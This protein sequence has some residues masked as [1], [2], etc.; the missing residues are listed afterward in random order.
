[1][2]HCPSSPRALQPPCLPSKSRDQR[3]GRKHIFSL[4]SAQP[5]QCRHHRSHLQLESTQ[6]TRP[7]AIVARSGSP[8]SSHRLSTIIPLLNAT[9]P[10]VSATGTY[11]CTQSRRTSSLGKVQERLW[12]R[13][14]SETTMSSTT[15]ANNAAAVFSLKS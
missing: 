5:R 8:S 2:F 6:T 10:S 9:A 13:I 15:S 3:C 4:H 1:M 14:A 11:S 12:G 7:I